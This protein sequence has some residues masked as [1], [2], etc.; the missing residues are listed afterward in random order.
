MSADNYLL[1]REQ[2]DG[3]FKTYMMSAS[4]DETQELGQPIFI[5]PTLRQALQDAQKFMSENIVEYGYTIQ[6]QEP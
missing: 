4:G 6:L 5:S 3:T 1:I 2:T